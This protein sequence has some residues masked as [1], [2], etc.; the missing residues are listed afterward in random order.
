MAPLSKAWVCGRSLAG[1]MNSNPAGV[2]D[3]SLVSVLCCQIEV[4]A[5]GRSLIQGIPPTLLC[6]IVIKKTHR[7]GLAHSGGGGAVEP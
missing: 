2:I 7:G 1:I 6:L 3:M 5:T 4:F